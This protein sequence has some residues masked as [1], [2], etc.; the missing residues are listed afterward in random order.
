MAEEPGSRSQSLH[1]SVEVRESG[2]SKG[3]QEDE[4]REMQT[5]GKEICVS[6]KC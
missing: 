1:K 6:A 2:W 5:E 3:R 4:L